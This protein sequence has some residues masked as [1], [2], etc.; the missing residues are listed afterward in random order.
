MAFD[1]SGY[2]IL[3]PEGKVIETVAPD[4]SDLFHF[5]NFID[6]IRNGTA[7]NAPIADAQ[8]SAMLCHLGNI[9]YRQD[10]TLNREANQSWESVIGQESPWWKRKY[11]EGWVS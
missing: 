10:A 11:R 2:K 4:F 5:E 9:A 8:V 3:D 7:L 1:S 6:A